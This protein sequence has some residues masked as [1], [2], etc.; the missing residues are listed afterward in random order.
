L[1]DAA[2]VFVA[3]DLH[4]NV[5]NF[6]S[7]L[8]KSDLAKHPRRHLVLQELIHGPFRYPTGGDKSHQMLDLLAALKCQYADR[9]HMLLGNH[10]LAQWQG[11]LVA[12]GDDDYNALFREGVTTAYAPFDEAV[13]AAYLELFAVLSLAVRTPNRVI[14]CHSLPSAEKLKTF[15]PAALE[16][17]EYADEDLRYGGSVHSLVWGRDVRPST[18]QAF[19]RAVDADWLITGHIP[20]DRGHEVPNDRQII[21]D[22]MKSPAC[23]CLFPADRP[24]TQAELI[25][26]IGTL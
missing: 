13:H 2:D 3:G 17:E 1:A 9:V 11:Q 15:D 10:E 22:S 24:I 4:G 21:L 20:C 18:A 19:L 6:R 5:E 26:C 14:L 16:Q 23:F 12:K 25:R 7:I 8:Q